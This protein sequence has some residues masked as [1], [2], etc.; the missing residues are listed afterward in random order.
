[1]SILTHAAFLIIEELDICTAQPKLVEGMKNIFEKSLTQSKRVTYEEW[2]Q[3]SWLKH[4]AL[5]NLVKF[6]QWQL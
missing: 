4:R 2:Q 5:G 1:M 3:R 6:F